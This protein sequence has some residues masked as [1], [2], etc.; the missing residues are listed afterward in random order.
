MK[1]ENKTKLSKLLQTKIPVN[2][3]IWTD[4]AKQIQDKYNYTASPGFISSV[5]R[6]TV[7]PNIQILN[8]LCDEFGISKAE[9]MTF[10]LVE[11]SEAKKL[12]EY[13]EITPRR[14]ISP[15]SDS[16]KNPFEIPLMGYV[17]TE[18]TVDIFDT[19]HDYIFMSPSVC[20]I[21]Q[22]PEDIFAI[23]VQGSSL[24]P[25]FCEGDLLIFRKHGNGYKTGSIIIVKI[26]SSKTPKYALKIYRS[27]PE[28][29]KIAALPITAKHLPMTMP[30]ETFE[31]FGETI[32]IIKQSPL[33][34]KKD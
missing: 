18:D 21:A 23:Q 22:W 34:S 19:P 17:T 7:K 30:P 1:I 25:N 8:I 31:I 9:V 4:L 28:K 16:N 24:E 12:K 11:F 27:F 13:V 15:S 5:V 2:T 33:C 26:N 14:Q 20:G 32:S 29:Q 6:G 3:I 10:Y